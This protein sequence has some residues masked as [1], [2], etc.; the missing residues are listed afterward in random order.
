MGGKWASDYPEIGY[1]PFERWETQNETNVNTQ[2]EAD[3]DFNEIILKITATGAGSTDIICQYR[4]PSDFI[5]FPNNS[6]DISVRVE[7]DVDSGDGIDNTLTINALDNSD[8]DLDD[9][10][11][12][13][14]VFG[15]A[16][17]T[18]YTHDCA[19]NS[20]GTLV[21]GDVLRVQLQIA[22]MDNTDVAK[23]CIPK[24]KYVRD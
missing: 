16:I 9:D 13:T 6:D 12:A 18:I 19:I 2:Q 23:V 1:L 8:A 22:A 3:D 11:V 5:E 14:T 7:Q 17:G 21:A 15:G 24:V 4:I 10:T 20:S